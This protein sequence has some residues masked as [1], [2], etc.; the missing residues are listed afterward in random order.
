MDLKRGQLVQR[1]PQ[2][3]CLSHN[4]QL[5]TSWWPTYCTYPGRVMRVSTAPR[6]HSYQ[7]TRPH[8][9]GTMEMFCAGFSGHCEKGCFY[10]Y[11]RRLL[12]KSSYQHW[13]I[14]NRNFTLWNLKYMKYE[15]Y[16]CNMILNYEYRTICVEFTIDM[17]SGAAYLSSVV[18]YLLWK[19]AVF[20]G[21]HNS[22]IQTSARS[23]CDRLAM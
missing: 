3:S 20:W 21:Q 2:A 9:S 16:E 18:P 4:S 1:E 5:A 12:I 11:I 7:V 14:C 15:L 8:M 22:G 6:S 10:E 23:R 19:Q 13:F 17:T